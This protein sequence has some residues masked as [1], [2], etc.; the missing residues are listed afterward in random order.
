VD[1]AG[2]S[3]LRISCLKT[4]CVMYVAHDD[5]IGREKELFIATN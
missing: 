4:R 2:T 5:K 3:A 1:D